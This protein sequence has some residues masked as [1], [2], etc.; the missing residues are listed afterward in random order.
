MINNPGDYGVIMECGLNFYEGLQN[1][2]DAC[3]RINVLFDKN[4]WCSLKNKSA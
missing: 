4:I 3:I 1:R 2:Q